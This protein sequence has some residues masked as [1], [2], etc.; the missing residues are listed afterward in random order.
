MHAQKENILNMNLPKPVGAQKKG[1]FERDV[2]KMICFYKGQIKSYIDVEKPNNASPTM[3][4]FIGKC[5]LFI[6]PDDGPNNTEIYTSDPVLIL[7][8]SPKVGRKEASL[9]LV[10]LD[11]FSEPMGQTTQ[12]EDRVFT[13]N[14]AH[15]VVGVTEAMLSTCVWLD[16]MKHYGGGMC[17]FHGDL[18]KH[19]AI[20]NQT[21]DLELHAK[22]V[23]DQKDAEE[24]TKQKARADLKRKREIDDE[25][26][27]A[28]H[29]TKHQQYLQNRDNVELN[30]KRREGKRPTYEEEGAEG[31]DAGDRNK[32]N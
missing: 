9:S 5:A 20:V 23:Q 4:Q 8:F 17:Y 3:Q 31:A 15:G 7:V 30:H 14:L 18:K 22:N 12:D 13:V 21:V 19:P 10:Y 1:M 25:E 26:R 28:E 24:A 32:E 29:A 27:A 11:H 2:N 6:T 16:D